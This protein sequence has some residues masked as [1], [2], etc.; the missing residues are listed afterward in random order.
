MCYPNDLSQVFLPDPEAAQDLITQDLE[1]IG[2]TVEPVA[3]SWNDLSDSV[4][5]GD[6]AL[7]VYSAWGTQNDTLNF[8]NSYL[9]TLDQFMATIPLI[10]VERHSYHTNECD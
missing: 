6:C 1:A 2:V 9:F 10:Q 7:Y 3:Q 4:R 5:E 8:L